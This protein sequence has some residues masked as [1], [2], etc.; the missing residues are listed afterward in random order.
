MRARLLRRLFAA[1]TVTVL[2]LGCGAQPKSSVPPAGAAQPTGAIV[3]LAAASLT[4]AFQRIG[5]AFQTSH[6][7]TKINFSFGSSATLAAQ[8]IQGAPA[9]VFAAA[10]EST[11]KTVTDHGLAPAAQIFATNTLQ[12]AVPRGN[13]GGVSG[14]HDFADASKRIAL[15]AEQVPCGQAAQ[16]IFER[17]GITP[18]P[19]TLESDVKAALQKVRLNEVDAALVY[20]TDVIAAGADVEGIDFDEPATAVNRYPICAVS[21]SANPLTARAFVDY[22]V[23]P[24]GQAVLSKAGFGSA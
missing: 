6:P 1:L 7:G 23:G 8:I 19:D 11:M 16:T 18:R 17:A 2:L 3:V 13:P 12:I 21:D 4:E 5:A 22:V 10:N 20:R 9:D 15:C 24:D 14:L